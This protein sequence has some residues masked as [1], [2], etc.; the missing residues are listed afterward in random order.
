MP[1]F[2]IS[3]DIFESGSRLPNSRQETVRSHRWLIS[4]NPPSSLFN[5]TIDRE[6]ELS[7][8]KADRPVPEYDEVTLHHQQHEIYAYGKYRWK[9]V[10]ISFYNIASFSGNEIGTSSI[11]K[12]FNE[13][14]F[15]GIHIGN[16]RT[17]LPSDA[18]GNILIKLLD[19][20]GSIIGIHKLFNA[21]PVK[22]DPSSLD[23]ESSGIATTD[24]TFRFDWAEFQE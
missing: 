17:R 5:N 7:A 3:N 21:W 1:G 6:I 14:L 9:P 16:H 12:L 15:E 8:K 2:N 19:G 23:Y 18:K 11:D 4:L 24:V 20:G 10:T 22:V 13:W